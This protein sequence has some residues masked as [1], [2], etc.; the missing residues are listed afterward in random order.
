M[1]GDK[2]GPDDR[3]FSELRITGEGVAATLFLD[4]EASKSPILL[5]EAW[6]PWS[7]LVGG[8]KAQWSAFQDVDIANKEVTLE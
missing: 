3:I 8:D 6:Y 5:D 1:K 2:I 4:A 7:E